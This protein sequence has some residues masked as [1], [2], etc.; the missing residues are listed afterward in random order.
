MNKILPY[1]LAGLLLTGCVSLPTK[2]PPEPSPKGWEMGGEVTVEHRFWNWF[3]QPSRERRVQ[4]LIAKAQKQADSLYG[5]GTRLEI[6]SLE[7]SW[8]PFS[9]LLGADLLGFVEDSRL[10]AAVWIPSPEK[11]LPVPSIKEEPQ[12]KITYHYPVIPEAAYN[13]RWEYTQVE[14]RTQAMM[15]EELHAQYAQGRILPEDLEEQLAELPPGGAVH[16]SL[17]RYE[18]ENAIS[19][20]FVFRL[21]QGGHTL[22]SRRGWDDIPYVPGG[23]ELWWNDLVLPLKRA[24][25]PPFN[26]E[27]QD[28]FQKKVYR[29][30]ILKEPKDGAQEGEVRLQ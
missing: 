13:S 24:V 5:T 3:F 30:I 4:I 8:S 26:L 1:F 14:Y 23:D 20:W 27:I 12:K 2:G 7:G 9:L 6:L 22:F 17:G 18:I 16:V 29:F 25:E 19:K 28:E 15:E 21:T 10:T 11:A